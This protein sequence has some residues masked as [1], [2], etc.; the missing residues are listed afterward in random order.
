MT[1]LHCCETGF[2]SEGMNGANAFRV[3]CGAVGARSGSS[4]P[5]MS[6]APPKSAFAER[7]ERWSRKKS[8]RFLPQRKVR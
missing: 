8:S 3:D 4:V 1:F 5:G 6:H 2:A 7:N